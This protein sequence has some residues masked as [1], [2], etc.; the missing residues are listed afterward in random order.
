MSLTGFDTAGDTITLDYPGAATA[1]PVTP[2]ARGSTY[3]A[4][5]LEDAVEKLTGEDVTSR[6]GATTRTPGSTPTP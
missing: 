3:T 2:D 4:A 6:S 1:D 5:N